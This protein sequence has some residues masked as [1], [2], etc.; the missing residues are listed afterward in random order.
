MDL[1]KNRRGRCSKIHFNEGSS[2][3][4]QARD[5]NSFD[6][7]KLTTHPQHSCE[8]STH[9]HIKT[10]LWILIAWSEKTKNHVLSHCQN[11][12]G[13]WFR[14]LRVSNSDSTWQGWGRV[15]DVPGN[16]SIGGTTADKLSLPIFQPAP[17]RDDYKM[18]PKPY[19]ENKELPC[20]Q[21]PLIWVPAKNFVQR[22][23][24]PPNSSS[25][26]WWR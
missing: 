25:R 9:R 11:R 3:E 24:M 20:L 16:V 26:K 6:V 23:E 14:S 10:R 21:I 15:Y 17:K 13:R 2:A 22:N 12:K 1:S 19:Y 8:Q 4:Q 18:T 5:I 7:I